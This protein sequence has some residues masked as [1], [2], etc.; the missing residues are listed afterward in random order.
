MLLSSQPVALGAEV[1]DLVEHP[2]EQRLG[3]GGG[4]AVAL[5]L[6]DLV[7]VPRNLQPRAQDP[8]L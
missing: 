8:R 6:H 2:V 1:I 7:A 5:K 3:R 4:Q